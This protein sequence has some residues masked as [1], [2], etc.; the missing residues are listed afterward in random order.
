[1]KAWLLSQLGSVDNI[2]LGDAPDPVAGK[3]EAVVA[4]QYAALNPADRYLAEGQYP[5]RPTFPH[6]LGRD[7]IGKIVE[8]G[9]GTENWKIGDE[10][11]IVRSEIGVSRAGTFAEKVAV[12]TESLVSHPAGWT[13]EQ[14]AGATL[15]YLTAWQ[16]LTQWG[17]LPPSLVLVTGASGGVGIATI[18]LAAALGHTVVGLSRGEGKV[19]AILEQGA[20]L[21][22]DPNDTQWRRKLKEMYRTRKVDL[23]VENIGGSLFNELLDVMGMNGRI[24]VVGRLAGPV[25]AFNTASLFFR[26]LRIGGVAVGTYTAAESRIAWEQLVGRLR[27]TGKA[28]LVDQVFDFTRLPDAFARLHSGP[29][30]KVLLKI[31]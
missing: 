20:S 6:I 30:G 23:V 24:S 10:V 11:V 14:S 27:Q 26:R 28:P 5:A 25:P 4:L 9:E 13:A 21:V 19:A 16:A 17:D 15:V 22:L 8:L 18:H 2:S 31:A 29:L 1:M 3:G 12:P 7:G